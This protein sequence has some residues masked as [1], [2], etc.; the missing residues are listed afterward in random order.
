MIFLRPWK[1]LGLANNIKP[2]DLMKQVI[3]KLIDLDSHLLIVLPVLLQRLIALFDIFLLLGNS[4]LVPL[5]I[6]LKLYAC[7]SE[8]SS[9]FFYIFGLHRKVAH[10]LICLR[11]AFELILNLIN[12]RLHFRL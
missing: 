3:L 9:Y 12:L 5:S 1:P 10:C 7:L 6:L 11:D 4:S 8:L 2:F